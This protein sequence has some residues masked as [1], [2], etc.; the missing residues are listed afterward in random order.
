MLIPYI[1]HKKKRVLPNITVAGMDLAAL[2]IH[3]EFVTGLS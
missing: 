3:G 2:K 1:K